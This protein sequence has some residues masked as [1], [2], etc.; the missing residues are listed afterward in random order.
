MRLMTEAV[1]WTACSVTGW[2]TARLV[3]A[4]AGW[5]LAVKDKAADLVQGA[6]CALGNRYGVGQ[7]HFLCRGHPIVDFTA[8]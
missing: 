6:C 3:V 4:A 7:L 5:S 2:S 8:R 1:D